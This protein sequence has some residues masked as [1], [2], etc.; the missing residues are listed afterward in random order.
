LE[1]K[2]II[3]FQINVCQFEGKVKVGQNRNKEDYTSLYHA[4]EQ[5][6]DPDQQNLAKIMKSIPNKL[7][8]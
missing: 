1:I 6:A 8:H 4:F 3:A 2:D 5:S 7:L